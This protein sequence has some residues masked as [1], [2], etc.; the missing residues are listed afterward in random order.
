MIAES[1]LRHLTIKTQVK[2]CNLSV[3]TFSLYYRMITDFSD[4][5]LAELAGWK[6]WKE[7]RAQE[8]VFESLQIKENLISG[9]L[10]EGR[11]KT[12][13]VVKLVGEDL[14][15][16]CSCAYFQQTHGFC[17]HSVALLLQAREAGGMQEELPTSATQSSDEDFHVSAE[18]PKP[19]ENLIKGAA[20]PLKVKVESREGYHQ[21]GGL[22]LNALQIP[23]EAGE[24]LIQLP[25]S[26]VAD[27]LTLNIKQPFLTHKGEFI[28]GSDS[29]TRFPLQLKDRK[30]DKLSIEALGASDWESHLL[31]TKLLLCNSSAQAYNLQALESSEYSEK[32]ATLLEGQTLDL[33]IAEFLAQ[34]DLLERW[35]DMGEIEQALQPLIKSET[36][37]FTLRI[38]GTVKKITARLEAAY[39]SFQRAVSQ[40]NPHKAQYLRFENEKVILTSPVAEGRA[41]QLLTDGEFKETEEGE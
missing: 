20:I 7:G 17:S 5:D 3:I 30:E 15:P 29:P 28:T 33:S 4:K 1:Q 40:S 12:R 37:Q 8:Q 25:A 34:A 41:S 35:F 38:E 24:H 27:L 22:I 18:L 19:L 31:E 16:S 36:P 32:L 13:T 21:N 26:Y 14:T 2:Y 11:K 6:A 23:A 39:S 9:F 10:K